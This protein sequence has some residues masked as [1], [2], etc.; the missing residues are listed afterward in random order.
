MKIS[1]YKNN[2]YEKIA[3]KQKLPFFPYSLE[4]IF[5][6]CNIGVEEIERAFRNTKKDYSDI[7]GSFEPEY[8]LGFKTVKAGKISRFK[9]EARKYLDSNELMGKIIDRMLLLLEKRIDSNVNYCMKDVLGADFINNLNTPNFIDQSII[10][11]SNVLL[12][13][14]FNIA[15]MNSL[16]V[17][18]NN[19]EQNLEEY[20]DKVE[21]LK[22]K[23]GQKPS[24]IL[25]IKTDAEKKE[26]EE[27][28]MNSNFYEQDLFKGIKKINVFFDGHLKGRN[29]Q[30]IKVKNPLENL[31]KKLLASNPLLPFHD[32]WEKRIYISKEIMAE[33]NTI[34]EN[35]LQEKIKEK[36]TKA[37]VL[38]F[39][40]NL[41]L[42]KKAL[43][44][45]VSFS[46]TVV[47]KQ[48]DEN[49]EN[50]LRSINPILLDMAHSSTVNILGTPDN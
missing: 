19:I 33:N 23:D 44:Q 45:N 50:I 24:S 36:N 48:R 11:F 14:E 3:F 6:I 22:R 41:L 13:T 17:K 40:I 49:T 1:Q 43:L 8:N 27:I 35:K 32:I 26:L 15:Y 38:R 47:K 42:M 31:F 39:I 10:G 16:E 29:K 30:Y 9:K 34:N 21:I 12:Q 4:D 2:E 37:H 25:K 7:S 5:T 18:K 20:L 46:D 28:A